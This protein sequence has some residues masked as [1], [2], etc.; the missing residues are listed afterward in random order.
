MVLDKEW[1]D[2]LGTA[3]Y[4]YGGGHALTVYKFTKDV[5]VS[6]LQV[7]QKIK[8]QKIKMPVPSNIY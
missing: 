8:F 6:F 5:N 3:T 2:I 1:Q 4:Q 7:P